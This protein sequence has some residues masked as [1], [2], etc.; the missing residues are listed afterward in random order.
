MRRIL[1][2]MMALIIGQN[3]FAEK[4]NKK[5]S[6]ILFWSENKELTLKELE[7]KSLKELLDKY[8]VHFVL[9]MA[10]FKKYEKE[11]NSLYFNY[12]NIKNNYDEDDI[13]YYNNPEV[14]IFYSYRAIFEKIAFKNTFFSIVVDGKIV[15]NGINRI[16]PLSAVKMKYDDADIPK[17]ILE[18]KD[19][20]RLRI[21]YDF[22]SPYESYSKDQKIKEKKLYIKELDYFFNKD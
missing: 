3:V 7:T 21:C 20:V 9:D 13:E 14:N 5:I 19:I 11:T 10:L 12:C 16:Q 6:E 1:F 4:A 2:I 15:M 17:L 8:D 18:D 22:I